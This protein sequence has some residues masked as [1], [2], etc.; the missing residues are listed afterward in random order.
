MRIWGAYPDFVEAQTKAFSKTYGTDVDLGV[1]A[2]DYPSIVQ[3]QLRQKQ[4]LDLVYSLGHLPKAWGTAGYIHDY[5]RFWAKEAAAQEMLPAVRDAVTIDGKLVGLP[6]FAFVNGALFANKQV[7]AKSGLDSWPTTYDELYAQVRKVKRSGA[8]DTP[9]LPSFWGAPWYGIPFGF[10]QE[11][12]NRKMPL[13]GADGVPEFDDSS[14][15]A[16]MLGQWRDLYSE[17][18]VPKGILTFQ[19]SDWIE[20]FAAG[21]I[22]YSPQLQY[23]LKTFADPAKSKV[24]GQI[25]AVPQDG[26]NW[27]MLHIGMYL[28][29]NR[30]QSDEELAQAYS[31]A[32]YF[33]Y[34][35]RKTKDFKVPIGWAAEN[36]LTQ[37]YAA[38]NNSPEV[39][40]ATRAWL[41]DADE[42]WPVLQ[43]YMADPQYAK[44]LY[45][46]NWALEWMSHASRELPRAVNGDASIKS[47]VRSLREKAE[48][49]IEEYDK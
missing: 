48:K 45:Q 22:A 29:G 11:A 26:Q 13:F 12:M 38:V 32:E 40:A 47:T 2:G 37:G 33:G 4:K 16:D 3:N 18:L 21:G 30:G 10:L 23:D 24:A 42:Q 14:G 15:V 20:T 6:Y 19:E 36:N 35:D 27:G 25:V 34:R 39:E 31:L 17:N 43:D 44:N 5:E 9:Y 41:P 28:I 1:I 7:L 49:L 46:T 8:S